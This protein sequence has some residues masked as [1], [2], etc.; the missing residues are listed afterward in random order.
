[1]PFV[2]S[3]CSRQSLLTLS[4]RPGY[5]TEPVAGGCS[6]GW[7][8]GGEGRQEGRGGEG[9]GAE[10]RELS[11][12]GER[13]RNNAYS[14]EFKAGQSPGI[15]QECLALQC[16][17]RVCRNMCNPWAGQSGLVLNPVPDAGAC[18]P[19]LRAANCR[20]AIASITSPGPS[21]PLQPSYEQQMWP[22]NIPA[23]F[24]STGLLVAKVRWSADSGSQKSQE[25]R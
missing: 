15:G 21:A 18:L 16:H 2:V 23:G 4:T 8:R 7:E 10:G 6:G 20:N 9:R 5:G 22:G 25:R 24:P 11:S 1:M 3:H 17:A 13:R 14:S 19:P 12:R